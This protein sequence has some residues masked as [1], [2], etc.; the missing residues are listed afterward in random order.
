MH[1]IIVETHLGWELVQKPK[2]KLTVQEQRVLIGIC[3][4]L[5]NHEIARRLLVS[6]HTVK[7]HRKHLKKKLNIDHTAGLI[8]YAIKEGLFK[9]L[10]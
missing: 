10:Y 4:Q 9:V 6:E 5:T 1:K 3:E 8:V 7:N 2:E